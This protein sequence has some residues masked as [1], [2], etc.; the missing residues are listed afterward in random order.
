MWFT[1][2]SVYVYTHKNILK[3]LCKSNHNAGP[4][5]LTEKLH[6]VHPSLYSDVC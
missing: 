3:C 5:K 6:A 1:E 4:L 2:K